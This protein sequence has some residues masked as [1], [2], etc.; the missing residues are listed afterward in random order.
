MG[1]N[2]DKA[3]KAADDINKLNILTGFEAKVMF[4]REIIKKRKQKSRL[5]Q[6]LKLRRR[7]RNTVMP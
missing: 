5:K 3:Y 7:N 2:M 6:Q 4:T 1:G